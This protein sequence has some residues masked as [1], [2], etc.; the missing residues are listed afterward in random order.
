MNQG[1]KIE[2]GIV[3]RAINYQESDKILT[4]FTADEGKIVAKL[5]SCR[6]PKAKLKFAGQPFCFAEWTLV[7][8]GEHCIVANALEIESF[9]D[10]SLDY[11]K[12]IVASCLL[13][14]CDY[15]LNPEE[16]SGALFVELLKCLKILAYHTPQPQIVFCKFALDLFDLS[17]Y[18]IELDRCKQ[19][20][21]EF[22]THIIF[23][24]DLGGF[25]CGM[26]PCS[27]GKEISLSA[28]KSLNIIQNTEIERLDSIKINDINLKE[29]SSVLA[30]N[31]A[32]RFNKHIKS[33]KV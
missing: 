14:M 2:K 26:C 12:L 29:I 28:L 3:L 21:G 22:N 20:N 8:K 11:D 6:Q 25:I 10:I 16:P 4:I 27:A 15:V 17:G 32:F 31:F 33:L 13:E 19:C 5:K 30:E 24:Y 23:D 18:K 1:E 9:F 7:Q